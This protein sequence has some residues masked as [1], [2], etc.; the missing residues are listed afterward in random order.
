MSGPQQ[1]DAHQRQPG[2]QIVDL[3]RTSG[4]VIVSLVAVENS[5][6]VEVHLPAPLSLEMNTVWEVCRQW[7]P[8]PHCSKVVLESLPALKT[9]DVGISWLRTS[10]MPSRRGPG[11]RLVATTDKGIQDLAD[12]ASRYRLSPRSP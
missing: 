6:V 12:H 2:T 8:D 3:L 9:G 7:F 10:L 5:E 11:D 4:A 1:I